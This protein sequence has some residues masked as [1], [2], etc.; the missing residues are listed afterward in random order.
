[1]WVVLSGLDPE[2]AP[3]DAGHSRP[4]TD[5]VGVALALQPSRLNVEGLRLRVHAGETAVNGCGTESAGLD[6]VR[7]LACLEAL[8]CRQGPLSLV[9]TVDDGKGL[10]TRI[11]LAGGMTEKREQGR[12]GREVQ[13]NSPAVASTLFTVPSWSEGER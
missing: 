1:V 8:R 4:G 12:G 13:G 5:C 10:C 7:L 2:T 3:D 9:H 11:E 6:L